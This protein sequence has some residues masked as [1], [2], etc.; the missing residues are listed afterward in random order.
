MKPHLPPISTRAN[1]SEKIQASS[2]WGLMTR[3]PCLSMKPHL[4]PI[5]TRANTVAPSKLE[6]SV[7]NASVG[8]PIP[9]GST[10]SDGSTTYV[11][12]SQASVIVMLPSAST[13]PSE[14]S[15]PA[16]SETVHLRLYAITSSASAD[17]TRPLLSTSPNILTPPCAAFPAAPRAVATSITT[18]PDAISKAAST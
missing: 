3:V 6:L 5:S 18:E 9:A 2:N 14:I 4:P 15:T 13:S 1:P 16:G 10:G 7:P 12:I 8:N 11:A 17:S